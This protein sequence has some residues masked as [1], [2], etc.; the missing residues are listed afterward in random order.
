[1]E[2]SDCTPNIC[3]IIIGQLKIIKA[4]KFSTEGKN[5]ARMNAD[6]REALN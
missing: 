1:M 2:I 4:N 3:T 6:Y 5:Y